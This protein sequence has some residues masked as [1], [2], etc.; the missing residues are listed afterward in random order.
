M[1]QLLFGGK[2]ELYHRIRPIRGAHPSGDSVGLPE[3]RELGELS[4]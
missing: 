1:S 2:H 4:L 3:A